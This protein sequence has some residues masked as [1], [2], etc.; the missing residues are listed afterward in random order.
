MAAHRPVRHIMC[1]LGTLLIGGLTACSSPRTAGEAALQTSGHDPQNLILATTTSTYDSGLLDYILPHFEEE[2]GIT[3]DVVAVGTGQAL[4][5]AAHGDA[6]V[7]LV[8]ARQR[9][10][11]FIAEGHGTRRYDVMYNDFVIVGPPDDPAGIRGLESAAEAFQRIADAK[12]TFIS[13]GDDSGTHIKE[14]MIWAQTTLT[15]EDFDSAWYLAA[16][17]SMGAVLT[18]ADERQAYTLSDRATYLAHRADPESAPFSLE[19][20]VEGD[21]ILFNPYSV[22]PVNPELH[23]GVNAEG[24][25]RFVEWLTSPGTQE[26]I[27]SY[28]RYGQPLFTPAS[29]AW[30]AAHPDDGS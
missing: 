3:V 30:R 28:E 11:E 12:A 14:R 16:G 15:E 20:M 10:E 19:I 21:P 5:M 27:A 25:Q 17:Q 1:V 26:L 23:P 4:A 8:H 22:I 7:V 24:A 18:M 13:R 29:E 9:E 6:D 2:T